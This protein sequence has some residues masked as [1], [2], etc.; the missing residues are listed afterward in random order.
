MKAIQLKQYGGPEQLV[1]TEVPK[2]QA[3]P[4]QVVVRI[5]A[6]SFNPVDPKRTS[7][8]MRQVFPIEFPFIPG[9]DFSGVI[10]SIG[11]G[12]G[13]FEVGDE[14]YGYSMPGGAYAEFVAVD[15]GVVARKPVSLN[16]VEAASLALVAQTASQALSEAKPS[17]GQTI[18]IHGAGGAVGG[19]AVQLA[20]QTGAR[21]IA[22]ASAESQARVRQYGADQVIDYKS[23]PFES[24]VKDVDVVLD[25]IGGDV[26]QRS[27]SVLKPGGLLL[28]MTQPPS[29]EKA[30]EHHVRAMM[31]FTKPAAANL[32][33]LAAQIDAGKIKPFVGKTAPLSS[34]AKVW[35][36]LRKQHVEGKIVFIVKE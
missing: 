16:H 6:T 20:H 17:A 8:D 1:L 7:G 15:P 13:D 3:K 9:G 25:T 4:G 29:Q 32:Q 10:D 19:V 2:P 11:E 22:T 24:I 34:V 35:A 33:T 12:V 27:F 31:L 21:V 36:D 14:V 28:A 26:Q 5:F 30:A 18:L 23:T